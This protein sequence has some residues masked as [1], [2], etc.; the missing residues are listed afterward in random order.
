MKGGFNWDGDH[1]I[2]NHSERHGTPSGRFLGIGCAL[3]YL[4]G[5]GFCAGAV[6]DED[7]VG[8]ESAGRM[9]NLA[10]R[11]MTEIFSNSW[12][13]TLRSK[14]DAVLSNL[15]HQEKYVLKHDLMARL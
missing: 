1:L 15:H 9:W 13:S 2:D 5:E 7:E 8:E 14:I 6:L 11:L 12:H 4:W 3:T 10:N